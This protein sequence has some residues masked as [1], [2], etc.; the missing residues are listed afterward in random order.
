MLPAIGTK[1][2]DARARKC[3]VPNDADDA[4]LLAAEHGTK[5]PDG[6]VVT[7]T[8][9][10]LP[11]EDEDEVQPTRAHLCACLAK[12][13]QCARFVGSASMRKAAH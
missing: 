6:H 4:K 13:P 10:D 8:I 5:L 11:S 3:G 7:C 1:E 9:D 12:S 2:R